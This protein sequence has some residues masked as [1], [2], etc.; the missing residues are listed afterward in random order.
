[1]IELS[2]D[3]MENLETQDEEPVVAEE[4]GEGSILLSLWRKAVAGPK[5]E[6]KSQPKAE[7][8]EEPEADAEAEAG[9]AATEADEVPADSD[10][11][12]LPPYLRKLYGD[13]MREYEDNPDTDFSAEDLF[14]MVDL[15]P[16]I[17]HAFWM[18]WRS[19][20]RTMSCARRRLPL[21]TGFWLRACCRRAAA[22]RIW[23]PCWAKWKCLLQWMPKP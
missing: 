13:W 14:T 3:K 1:M 7:L 20:P 16:N 15:K 5:S 10:K 2:L 18:S 8:D 9:P 11:T 4:S 21:K 19:A 6:K 12:P 23:T 22:R 17:F